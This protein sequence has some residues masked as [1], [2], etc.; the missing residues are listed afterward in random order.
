MKLKIK[1][2]RK[3]YYSYIQSSEWKSIKLKYL[4]SN[5][6]KD[7]FGCNKEYG[8][9]QIEFHHR[10]YKRLGCERL[11]DI[12]PVCRQCH[13]AIHDLSENDIS[14]WAA[15]SK[16]KRKHKRRKRKSSEIS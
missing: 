14:L 8:T 10:T 13:Q 16:L 12:V 6:P 3:E 4:R 9:Y 7:C 1:L 11:M 2:T 5:L 15:T